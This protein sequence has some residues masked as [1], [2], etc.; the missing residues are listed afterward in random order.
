MNL[1][2][3]SFSF[4]AMQWIVVTAIGIYAWIIGRQSASAQEM[5]EL[6]I[7]IT[8]LE[9]QMDQVPS[10]QQLHDLVT[11]VERVAGGIESVAARI[12]PLTRSVDRVESFLLN[13]K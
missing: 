12:E 7:R 1:T 9:A 10:Q 5:M 3:M 8:T 4:Q 2:D 6:R 11:K 13:Q